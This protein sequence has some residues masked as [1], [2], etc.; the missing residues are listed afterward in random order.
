MNTNSE[1]PVLAAKIRRAMLSGPQAITRDATIIDIDQDGNTVVLRA[2]KN[3][4]TCMPGNENIIGNVPMCADPPGMQWIADA[5]ARKRGPTNTTPGVCYMLC[6]A[7]Q[8]SNTDP[9]D[10]TSPPIP[11]GPHW[12]ILWPFNAEIY[13]LPTTVRDAG[14]WIMFANTPYAYLH[15]CGN[16]WDGNVYNDDG[17]ATWTM[18]YPSG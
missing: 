9:F 5:R 1:D 8:H 6:G 15:I 3:R 16:P 18:A 10:T 17:A 7:L 13:G 2:G 11:I 4:W 14:A 12:M